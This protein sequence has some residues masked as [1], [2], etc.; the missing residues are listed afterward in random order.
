MAWVFLSAIAHKVQ[1]QVKPTDG[2]TS[3]Y[4]KH[5]FIPEQFLTS[6]GLVHLHCFFLFSCM[7]CCFSLYVFHFALKDLNL[8]SPF[9][10]VSTLS[11]LSLLSSLCL[12][13]V[14]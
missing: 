11:L 13:L 9:S 7:P 8:T 2:Y 6:W 5:W 4:R 10:L 1:R 12:N 3:A 14:E